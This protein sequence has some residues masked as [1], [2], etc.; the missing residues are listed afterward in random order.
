MPFRSRLTIYYRHAQSRGRLLTYCYYC[1]RLTQHTLVIYSYIIPQP[2]KVLRRTS[3]IPILL[4]VILFRIIVVGLLLV[5]V[6]GS[7]FSW[8]AGISNIFDTVRLRWYI[9]SRSFF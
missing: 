2:R 5:I 3:A 9:S 8:C 4:V 6:V 1:S 7:L